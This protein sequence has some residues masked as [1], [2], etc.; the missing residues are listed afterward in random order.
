M[1]GKED[2]M[3]FIK[4][5]PLFADIAAASDRL[6]RL[7]ERDDLWE[8]DGF[9]ARGE[10]VPAVDIVEGE[11][12]VTIKAELPGIE[13]KDVTISVDNNVLTL[14]GERRAEKEVRKENYHRMERS[15]GAFSRSFALPATLDSDKVKADFR[16]GL[17]TITLPKK[18]AAKG[19]LIEVQTG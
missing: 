15:F 16:N 5:N 3:A 2:V 17:L 4:V 12:D 8:T 1:G 9:T 10:W 18:E 6:N 19:R 7:M 11:R 14:K 13:A